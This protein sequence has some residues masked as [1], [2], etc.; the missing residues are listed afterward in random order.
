MFF[1]R[2]EELC[3]PQSAQTR[4]RKTD[5]QIGRCTVSLHT[6]TQNFIFLNLLYWVMTYKRGKGKHW[7]TEEKEVC[8]SNTKVQVKI[9]NSIE[10]HRICKEKKMIPLSE[11][12]EQVVITWW[13]NFRLSSSILIPKLTHWTTFYLSRNRNRS[14][15]KCNGQYFQN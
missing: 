9:N 13:V 8:P 5:K 12:K 6:R 4:V 11:P 2:S 15:K 14:P 7:T 1:A 10:N 3:F